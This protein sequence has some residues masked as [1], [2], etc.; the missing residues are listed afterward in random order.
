MFR[1][2]KKRRHLE[3]NDLATVA[4]VIPNWRALSKAEKDHLTDDCDRLLRTKTWEAARGFKISQRMCVFVA[5]QAALLILELDIDH[6][7]DVRSIIL[8][9]T[10][11]VRERT[12]PGPARGVLRSGRMTILG[13]AAHGTGPIV[14]AWDSLLRET[15]NPMLGTNVVFHEF[16]HKIDMLDGIVDGTPPIADPNQLK[17]WVEVCT[18]AFDR[19]KHGPST[20]PLRVYAATNP[21]E[22]FAVATETFFTTPEALLTGEPDVYEVLQEFYRQDPAARVKTSSPPKAKPGRTPWQ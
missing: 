12:S 7:R 2:A 11:L 4:S 14:I 3:D 21:G 18:A 8:H 9:P 1:R 22:F 6:Y 17:H 13:E 15:Q 10:R 5:A 19:V 16:A 20:G